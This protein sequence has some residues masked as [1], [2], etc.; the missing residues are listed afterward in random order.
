MPVRDLNQQSHGEFVKRKLSGI[1][2]F[3]RADASSLSLYLAANLSK[4]VD[5][6][7]S[8]HIRILKQLS[9]SIAYRPV[10]NMTK[11]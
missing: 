9:C 2:R 8:H 1:S 5:S 11:G 6:S 4:S 10:Y 3:G 7:C